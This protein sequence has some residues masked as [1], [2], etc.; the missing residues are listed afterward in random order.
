MIMPCPNR[1]PCA[2][3][4]D[5]PLA[6]LSSEALDSIQQTVI[7]TLPVNPLLGD[8]VTHPTGTGTGTA[9][10]PPPNTGGGPPG[11]PTLPNVVVAPP[12]PPTIDAQPPAVDDG[13]N[14]NTDPNGNKIPTF[15]ND[16]QQAQATCEV[17]NGDYCDPF[18]DTYNYTLPGNTVSARSKA[19]AN[20]IAKSLAQQ[21]ADEQ[22][23][24]IDNF[25][26]LGCLDGNTGIEVNFTMTVISGAGPFTW[27]I[28]SAGPGTDL[29]TGLTL[30]PDPDVDGLCH[31][32]GI[33][34]T[35]G[36]GQFTVKITDAFGGQGL[37]VVNWFI[38]GFTDPYELPACTVGQFYSHQFAVE[39]W[40]PDDLRVYQDTGGFAPGLTLEVSGLLHGTPQPSPFH[41]SFAGLR[42]LSVIPNVACRDNPFA[43][44]EATC[45]G[46]FHMIINP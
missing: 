9:P 31:I 17:P 18:I 44:T 15:Q 21:R 14:G 11:G 22:R 24:C 29:P 10:E 30:E 6:N 34:T 33:P 19:E 28:D 35:A 36:E 46:D 25:V 7:L 20:A 13:N 40:N 4:D 27:E 41:E 42:L 37:H 16:P 38:M 26:M 23:I 12:T 39:G 32:R 45:F 3:C 8:R 2:P 43:G 5:P 1:S